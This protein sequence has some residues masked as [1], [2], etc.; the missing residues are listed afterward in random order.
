MIQLLNQW[1]HCLKHYALMSLFASGPNK[2]PYRLDCLTLTVFCYCL[3]GLAL[4]DAQRSFGVVLLQIG[5]EISLLGLLAFLGLKWLKKLSRFSQCFSALVGVNFV[6]SAVTIPVFHWIT[7][8]INSD[9][10]IDNSLLYVTM[11][12]V[13]W[14][15]AAISQILKRTFE[16]NT[17]MSAMIAINY[18]LIYQFSV[19]WFY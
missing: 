13:I 15:L 19:V 5:L 3:L 17:V 9:G 6:I 4:V 14:N 18:F 16:I 7:P 1:L 2:L 11:A 10:N 8:D 12:M